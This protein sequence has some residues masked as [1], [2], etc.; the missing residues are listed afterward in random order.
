M[1]TGGIAAFDIQFPLVVD[2]SLAIVGGVSI[3]A[4]SFFGQMA[5]RE[6]AKLEIPDKQPQK[7]RR[8]KLIYKSKS[9]S[10]TKEIM[11]HNLAKTLNDFNERKVH[12]AKWLESNYTYYQEN[13]T[14]IVPTVA[15]LEPK[16]ILALQSVVAQH[17]SDKVCILFAYEIKT[18]FTNVG[19]NI[20]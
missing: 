2:T 16:G 7:N 14:A 17:P 11:N 1:L 20:F 5:S 13:P 15:A 12:Y 10:K 8:V 19:K 6:L 9:R 18:R 3:G 4:G